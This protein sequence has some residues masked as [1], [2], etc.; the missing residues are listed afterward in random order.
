[1]L[2]RARLRP[3]PFA[4]ARSVFWGCA[5]AL[6]LPG[7]LVVYLVALVGTVEINMSIAPV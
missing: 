4:C 3:G 2:R 6:G 5:D 7:V 1:M